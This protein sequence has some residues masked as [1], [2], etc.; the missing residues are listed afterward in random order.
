MLKNLLQ[1]Q[2][3]LYQKSKTFQYKLIEIP[4]ERYIS[5]ENYT[6]QQIIDEQID[7]ITMT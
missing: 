4:K 7:I 1:V 3:K 5:P 2:I 6:R